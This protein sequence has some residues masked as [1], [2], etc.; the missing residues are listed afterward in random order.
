MAKISEFID[1]LTKLQLVTKKDL[2][3]PLHPY[4]ICIVDLQ[5]HIVK[6]ADEFVAKLNN[7]LIR[8]LKSE[9]NKYFSIDWKSERKYYA[10]YKHIANGT[11]FIPNSTIFNEP[12]QY[13]FNVPQCSLVKFGEYLFSYNLYYVYAFFK[14]KILLTSDEFIELFKNI[15]CPR[16]INIIGMSCY[17]YFIIASYFCDIDAIKYIIKNNPKLKVSLINNT[18]SICNMYNHKEI[19]YGSD[20]KN[21][22]GEVCNR[23]QLMDKLMK[24]GDIIYGIHDID[25]F[26]ANLESMYERGKQTINL[27]YY[28]WTYVRTTNIPVQWSVKNS[29]LKNL[30]YAEEILE[31]FLQNNM[32]VLNKVNY[33]FL[34][35]IG[36]NFNDKEKWLARL[37]DI[38]TEKNKIDHNSLQDKSNILDIKILTE[39]VQ[40][41]YN[42]TLKKFIQQNSCETNFDNLCTNKKEKK[43]KM[44]KETIYNLAQ[45]NVMASVNN[46]P[47]IF[48]C[49]SS[50]INEDYDFDLFKEYWNLIKSVDDTKLVFEGENILEYIISTLRRG[51]YIKYA[52]DIFLYICQRRK[53][54]IT[55]SLYDELKTFN[56]QPF[57]KFAG[58]YYSDDLNNDLDE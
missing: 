57:L 38:Y 58:Y 11:E 18:T 30:D 33:R 7:I 6:N 35:D 56:M 28:N 8:R 52:D 26:F 46:I 37:L 51:T 16:S 27:Y 12:T 14:E 54:L 10:F 25:K 34:L 13:V 50:A 31:L 3:N 24:M 43:C 53:K 5:E 20:R 55:S 19:I 23:Q 21:L 9:S 47:L 15:I 49:L 45:A 44:Q 40:K 42:A 39:I 41:K 4:N 29:L 36:T 17:E 32:I 2:R 48:H 22:S 1:I